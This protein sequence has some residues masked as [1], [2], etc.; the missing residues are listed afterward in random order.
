MHRA[1]SRMRIVTVWL[2]HNLVGVQLFWDNHPPCFRLKG[3]ICPS[4]IFVTCR[5]GCRVRTTDLR[6]YGART[7]ELGGW[8]ESDDRFADEFESADI[9]T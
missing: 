8:E 4:K 7:K 1:F 5:N 3:F 6:Q 2:C 9:R